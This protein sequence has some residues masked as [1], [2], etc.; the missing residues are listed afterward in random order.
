MRTLRLIRSFAL[1]EANCERSLYYFI[2]NKEQ[3][4]L[5]SPSSKF[6]MPLFFPSLSLSLSLSPH[7]H[8]HTR[9]YMSCCS[10][11]SFSNQKFVC[12]TVRPT[13]LPYKEL[14][15]FDGAARFV[16]EFLVYVPLKNALETV[17]IEGHTERKGKSS[18]L[19]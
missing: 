17:R 13:L 7:T 10:N 2:F 11:S 8:T 12:T 5:S 14:Y 16:S 15:T 4:L 6:T 1:H 3:T 9:M 19:L 18:E